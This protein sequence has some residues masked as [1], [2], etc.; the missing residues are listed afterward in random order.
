VRRHG[1]PCALAGL[2][3]RFTRDRLIGLSGADMQEKT[4]F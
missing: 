4:C 2:V 1:P 3:L